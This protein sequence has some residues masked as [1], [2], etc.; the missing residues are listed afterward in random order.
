MEAVGAGAGGEIDDASVEAA[1]LGGDVVG[2][3][4]E[5]CD[6]VND[7]EE[8]DL[9]GFGLEGG[10]TVVE[11]LVGAGTAAVDAGQE[12]SRGEFDAGS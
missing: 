4:G 12:G 9:A 8:G 7:G 5:L 2:L 1:K 6:G 10:D 3:D 11:V